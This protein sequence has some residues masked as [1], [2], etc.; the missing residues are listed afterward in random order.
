M[1][2]TQVEKEG[3]ET[4]INNNADNRVITGSGTANTLN[5][6]SSV[7][8]D[9]NGKLGVGTTSPGQPLHLKAASNATTLIQIEA[10][11]TGDGT[12]GFIGTIAAA[13]NLNNG[14]LA[15]ELALRGSSG[16]SFSGNNGSATQLRLASG[17]NL[18]LTD[19]DLVIGTGGHGIDFSADGNAGGMSS[20]LLDDYEEGTWTAALSSGE[21]CNNV[22][23]TYTRIGRLV[24]T[25][26]FV[27]NFSDFNGNSAEFRI[28]GLPF[29]A[30]NA[31][32]GSYHGGGSITYAHSM[33]YSYPL[34]P[35]VGGN[36]DY[37][38]FHRQDGTTA[39]WKYQDFHNTGNGSG[40]N[41]IVNMI[42]ETD[43]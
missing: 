9:A 33:N 7:V 23:S 36:S 28:T 41:L 8:I 15:G 17:G 29:P 42:Y 16:I 40:G 21:T 13:D 26:C 10:S 22:Q 4:L 39:S 5:G 25:N 37:I 24:V 35:L 14:S 34:L 11:P 1:G 31:Q 12:A 38:Y 43:Y 18:T 3:I 6:E 19:G 32:G 2:L 27:N 30:H 20:E